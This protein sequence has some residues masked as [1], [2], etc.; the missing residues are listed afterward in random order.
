MG[1]RPP[2]FVEKPWGHE[3]IFAETGSYMGKILFVRAG[4]SLSLQYHRLKEETLRVLDGELEL[5]AG[6]EVE[7]LEMVVLGP[8]SVYHVP[9]GLIH[10]M[11]ART[12]CTVLEVSTP[13]RDDVVRIEDRYGREGTSAP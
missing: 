4:E 12:D 8:G 7:R 13:G 6:T 10:R 9:P 11:A 5:T 2:R 1:T 3:E